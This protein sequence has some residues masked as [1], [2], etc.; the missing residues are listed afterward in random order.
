[1]TWFPITVHERKLHYKCNMT[2]LLV[3]LPG[4]VKLGWEEVSNH[5]CCS[6]NQK[7]SLHGRTNVNLCQFEFLLVSIVS[8][9]AEA[10][11]PVYSLS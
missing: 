3:H 2:H 4:C 11:F 9:L 7:Q 10:P 1:M 8:L 6:C 5:S